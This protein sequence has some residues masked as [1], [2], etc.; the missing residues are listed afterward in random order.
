MS[1]AELTSR[2]VDRRKSTGVW[3]EC[4]SGDDNSGASR[5]TAAAANN[6]SGVAVAPIVIVMSRSGGDVAASGLIKCPRTCSGDLYRT[7]KF[8]TEAGPFA[9]MRISYFPRGRVLVGNPTQ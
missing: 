2:R 6:H 1:P 5:L 9:T 4:S 8:Q 3:H 7:V